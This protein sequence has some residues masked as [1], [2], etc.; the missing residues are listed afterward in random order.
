VG[1]PRIRA[2]GREQ[3]DVHALACLSPWQDTTA[4]PRYLQPPA[5]TLDAGLRLKPPETPKS[6]ISAASGGGTWMQAPDPNA[7][8]IEDSEDEGSYRSKDESVPEALPSEKGRQDTNTRKD[9]HKD[10]GTKL[11]TGCPSCSHVRSLLFRLRFYL[12]QGTD[13][14]PLEIMDLLCDRLG[15]ALSGSI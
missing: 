1:A 5:P 6:A 2:E 14:A 12:L 7:P 11:C 13:A 9:L 15:I 3:S 8:P 4:D 10:S